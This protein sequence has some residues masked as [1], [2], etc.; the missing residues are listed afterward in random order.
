MV[1]RGII[2]AIT[3]N[4]DKPEEIAERTRELLQALVSE[5]NIIIE[6]IASALFT[7]TPDIKSA[8]PAQAARELGWNR[9]PL[10]CFQEIEVDGS[11]PRCIRVLLH[12]NTFKQQGEIKHVYLRDA[13]RLRQDLTAAEST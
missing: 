6:D 5:N 13:V 8:F 12:V 10:L 2:G 3:V 1:L 9:V 11:L 4:E 7:V